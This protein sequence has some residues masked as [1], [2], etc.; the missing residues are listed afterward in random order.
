MVAVPVEIG[1]REQSVLVLSLGF[2]SDPE[3]TRAGCAKRRGARLE[4]ALHQAP[5]AVG[6][7]L[8]EVRALD[9]TM[10]LLPPAPLPEPVHE[11][12]MTRS[13]ALPT[14]GTRSALRGALSQANSR[15]SSTLSSDRTSCAPACTVRVWIGAMARSSPSPPRASRAT[16]RRVRVAPRCAL[17]GARSELAARLA[18]CWQ[19]CAA[20]TSA[21]GCRPPSSMPGPAHE[22]AMTRPTTLPTVGT[23]S[24]L[25]A[26]LR[27]VTSLTTTWPSID[28]ASC[29]RRAHGDAGAD[30]KLCP[31]TRGPQTS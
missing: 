30:H 17:E 9:L 10:W 6:K 20:S 3:M 8:Q 15:P 25:R 16:L 29:A 11:P 2:P 19:R 31:A 5:K 4:G 7:T 22:P 12:A 24:A 21:R 1:T 27:E 28:R 23:R 26:V 13:R 14:V 18:G